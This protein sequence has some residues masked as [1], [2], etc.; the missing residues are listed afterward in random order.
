MGSAV[1]IN[2]PPLVNLVSIIHL[3]PFEHIFQ[4]YTTFPHKQ[5]HFIPTKVN[6]SNAKLCM[7]TQMSSYFLQHWDNV[8]YFQVEVEVDVA[9]RQ[10]I[11]CN[12]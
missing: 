1:T 4:N 7:V 9:D 8:H 6:A 3:N 12:K 5:R 2:E 11:H 10:G